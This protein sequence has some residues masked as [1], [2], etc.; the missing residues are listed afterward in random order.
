MI[1]QA[2]KAAGSQA[3]TGSSHGSA[4]RVKFKTGPS[5]PRLSACPLAGAA[6][7]GLRGYSHLAAG[8]FDSF[9]GARLSESRSASL[10]KGRTVIYAGKK[11][12]ETAKKSSK[13]SKEVKSKPAK[14]EASKQPSK[15]AAK[16]TWESLLPFQIISSHPEVV[17]PQGIMTGFEN[18]L[19]EAPLPLFQGD[20]LSCKTSSAIPPWQAGLE[21]P[22]VST[23]VAAFG[24]RSVGEGSETDIGAF[25]RK[26]VAVRTEEDP[27]YVFD[28]GLVVRL[29]KAW[30]EAMPRVEPFYAVKCNPDPALLSVLAALGA[31]E[32][33][34]IL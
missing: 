14:G 9:L 18:L 15:E 16:S 29:F 25:M 7:A 34:I 2:R 30:K 5:V 32:N 11:T 6:L 17:F 24:A 22:R 13:V 20:K 3:L 10:R 23:V 21:D 1:S 12:V 8:D 31:G 4:R 19:K 33:K 28:M 26:V 27:F